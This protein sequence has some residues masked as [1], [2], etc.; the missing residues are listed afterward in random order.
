MEALEVCRRDA[1]RTPDPRKPA[2]LGDIDSVATGPFRI[3]VLN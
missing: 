1:C 2:F 3:A